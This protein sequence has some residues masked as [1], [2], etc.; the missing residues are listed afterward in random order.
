MAWK[1]EGTYFESCT[2][3]VACPCTVSSLALPADR[4]HCSV[5]LAFDIESGDVEGVDVSGT[6]VGLVAHAPQAQMTDGNWKVGLV[7]DDAASDEQVEKLGAVFGGQL[8]GPFEQLGPLIAENLGLTRAS[9]DYENDGLQHRLKIGDGA[10]VEIEDLASP[11]T[12]EATRITNVALPVGDTVTI[13]KVNHCR[14]SL[15]GIEFEGNT[16]SAAP[17]TMA[18]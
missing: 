14:V 17:F 15:H 18:A 11:E 16:G 6:R 7:V 13:A 1:I 5:L 2:C 3:D 8:G 4:D 9:F 10:D 12:G